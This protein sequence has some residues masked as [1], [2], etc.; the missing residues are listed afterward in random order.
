MRKLTVRAHLMRVVVA[1]AT[2]LVSSVSATVGAPARADAQVP[3]P[4]R[5]LLVIGGTLADADH[6]GWPGIV[7]WLEDRGGYQH[8][9]EEE[10][11]AQP[12]DDLFIGEMCKDTS[13]D[14]Y[15]FWKC[16][17]LTPA[18]DEIDPPQPSGWNPTVLPDPWK[19]LQWT[20]VVALTEAGGGSTAGW[21]AMS[22]SV[23]HVISQINLVRLVTGA[24]QI[25]II[26]HSQAGV[27]ARAAVRKIVASGQPSPVTRLVAL[28]APQYGAAPPA[29]LYDDLHN[30]IPGFFDLCRDNNLI[31]FCEDIF[32]TPPA[33]TN[34]AGS[35]IPLTNPLRFTPTSGSPIPFTY[36]DTPDDFYTWLNSSSAPGRTPGPTHYYHLY[37]RDYDGNG[38]PP[39]DRERF[40]VEQMNLVAAANVTNLN[41]QDVCSLFG[42]PNYPLHHSAEFNDPTMRVL[43]GN[44]LGFPYTDPEMCQP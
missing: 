27:I 18:G 39:T 30:L 32:L 26:A 24:P 42:V 5:P 2:V 19:N 10:G 1:L 37:T 35:E 41:V 4:P 11:G 13:D 3:T 9:P 38:N 20:D 15:D 8:T 22:K 7:A 6:S 16:S 29:P 12:G 33:S 25:D 23:D 34:R 43:I 17:L 31:P 21:A 36:R 44:A 14:A 40:I 28:G